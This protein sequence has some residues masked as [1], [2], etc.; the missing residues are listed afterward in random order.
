[1][2]DI[3]NKDILARNH[4]GGYIIIRWWCRLLQHHQKVAGFSFQHVGTGIAIL[5]FLLNA[6]DF[7]SV[8]LPTEG[9][10]HCRKHSFQQ[11]L[12]Y[13]VL[14][15]SCGDVIVC[16]CHPVMTLVYLL[17]PQLWT[18][19]GYT[20]YQGTSRVSVMCSMLRN[21]TIWV[22]GIDT[23]DCFNYLVYQMVVGLERGPLSL[24]SVTEELLEWESSGSGSRKPRLVAVGIRCADHVT[25]S[26]KV[27]TNFANKWQ[28]LSR[29]SSFVN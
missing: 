17:I 13:C 16:D 25:P 23:N 2:L 26:A 14:I 12:C 4:F 6:Q 5:E 11:L 7:F 22:Y 21:N 19:N 1:M 27:G 3:P 8:R 9:T 28:S 15:C 24:V 10:D 29:Y 18:I 20:H